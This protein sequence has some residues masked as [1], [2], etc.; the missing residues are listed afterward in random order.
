MQGNDN[1]YNGEKSD[2]LLT[3]EEPL[4][5]NQRK[6]LIDDLG[7]WKVEYEDFD[8]SDEEL[9]QWEN[10]LKEMDD[11]ELRSTW[12]SCVGEWLCHR[13]NLHGDELDGEEWVEQQFRKLL[14]GEQTDYGY[15]VL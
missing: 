14:N 7:K 4:A 13:S 10:H 9:A 2:V 1:E 11:D 12:R 5:D 15:C 6:Q 3:D 8:I